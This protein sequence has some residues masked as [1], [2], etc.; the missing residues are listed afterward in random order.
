MDKVKRFFELKEEWKSAKADRRGEV[1][2]ELR[3]LMDK[4]L[5]AEMSALTDGVQG[6]FDRMKNEA[7]EI[8]KILTVREKLESV[9]PYIS[10]STIAKHYFGKTS[11]WFYQRLN[12]NRGHGK[13]VSFSKTEIEQLNRAIQDISDKLKAVSL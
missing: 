13:P 12:G 7:S 9:L 1:D 2:R 10:V 4:M 3:E 8:R 11:S 5:D 6:D